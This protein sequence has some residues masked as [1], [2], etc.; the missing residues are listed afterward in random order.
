MKHTPY[1]EGKRAAERGLSP[2]DNPYQDEHRAAMWEDGFY[3]YEPKQKV[4]HQRQRS[5]WQ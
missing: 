1:T 3:F 4:K 2:D 5:D